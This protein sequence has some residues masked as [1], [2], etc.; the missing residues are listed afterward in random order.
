MR[1]VKAVAAELPAAAWHTYPLRAGAWGPLVVPFAAVRVW[2]VRHR[3]PGPPAWLVIRRSVEPDPEVKYDV[4]N[5]AADTPLE[6][7]A[8]VSGCR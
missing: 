6:T 7:L 8:L 2:A 4:A 5:A 1:K 3:Q